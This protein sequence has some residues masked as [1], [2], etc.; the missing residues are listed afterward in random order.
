MEAI[1][2]FSGVICLFIWT[3]PFEQRLFES[4]K[5]LLIILIQDT[6]TSGSFH[7]SLKGLE[8]WFQVTLHSKMAMSDSQRYL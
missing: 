6:Y 8:E 5:N 4:K 2:V 7:V 1:V 3:N